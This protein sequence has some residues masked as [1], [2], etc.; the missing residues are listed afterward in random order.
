MKLT[1]RQIAALEALQY[2][3]TV[4]HRGDELSFTL[5]PKEVYDPV[6]GSLE[7][8][9]RDCA[10]LARRARGAFFHLLE[11][12]YYDVQMTELSTE[13]PSE[14]VLSAIKNKVR[15]GRVI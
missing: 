7:H 4:A 6:F 5:E 3:H 8:V 2:L 9:A 13:N 1:A 12:P 10:E 15:F 11:I 14:R